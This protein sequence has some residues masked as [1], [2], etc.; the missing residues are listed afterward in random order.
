MKTPK[1][2]NSVNKVVYCLL[3]L[4]LGMFG[5]HKFYARKI[6]AGFLYLIL[7]FTG[8]T[9]FLA[10][11]DLIVAFKQARNENGKIMV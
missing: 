5:V 6:K 8:I 7:Y 4:T 11:Y 10:F 1:T 3:A 9:P 2:L